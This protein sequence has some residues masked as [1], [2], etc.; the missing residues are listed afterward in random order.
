ML[1][2]GDE[3]CVTHGAVS[4]QVRQLEERLGRPLTE[5]PRNRLRLTDD[6]AR[7]AAVLTDAFD[8]IAA[9]APRSEPEN[10]IEISC[11][12]TF[13]VRWLIPRL[14]G[15]LEANPD[16]RVRVTESFAPVDFRRDAF[17]GAIRM[18]LPSSAGDD[19]EVTPFLPHHFGPV[20]SPALMQSVEGPAA[21]LS[22][23]RL[24]TATYPDGWPA[25][26]AAAGVALG[27]APADRRFAF[28]T[29]MLEAACAGLG[30]AVA[31]WVFVAPDVL[32][33]RLVAP[34]GFLHDPERRF[35]FLRPKGVRNRAVDRFRDWLVE[36]G[37]RT[38]SPPSSA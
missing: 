13:A 22:L 18:G 29:S 38:P 11:L 26:G 20:V 24:H 27:P 14:S 15:F 21:V 28:N 34:L 16:L 30:V 4:R 36:E 3:L 31:T 12:T 25:W 23:P 37:A 1:A 6:G 35:A 8:R 9:A 5:G 19:E 10:E 17:H 7:F 33:G 2:A 32:S